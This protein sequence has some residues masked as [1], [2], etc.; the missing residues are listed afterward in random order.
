MAQITSEEEVLE[1]QQTAYELIQQ[2]ELEE[3][4]HVSAALLEYDPNNAIALNFMGIIFLEEQRP[5][6]AYQY[7]RRAL[8]E[9]SDNAQ[10]W[11]NFGMSAHELHRNSEAINSYLKSAELNNGYIKAYVNA[12][13]VF[14]EESR[15]DEAEKCCD[16]A[17]E[18]DPDN[19]LA[20]K[21]MAHVYLAKHRWEKGWEYWE[22]SLGCKYRKEWVYGKEERWDGS[23]DKAV[24]VYGEQGLGDEIAYS[25]CIPDLINDSKKVIIDCDPRLEK[26]F[27]RSFPNADVYGTRR[28]QHPDWLRYAR[29]DARVAMASLPSFYRNSDEAFPGTPYLKPD[30]NLVKMFRTYFDTFKKPVY[31]ICTHGGSK[32]TNEK[33]RTIRPE[34]FSSLFAKDAV[35]VS[36][37]YKSLHNNKKLLY[38]P[39]VTG[40]KDYDVT[41]ALIAACDAVIGVNTTAMHCA[42][43]MGIPTH[44]LVSTF[45]QWRYEGE[46]VWSKTAKLYHQKEGEEWRDVIKRVK[47]E[48]K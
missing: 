3:A 9:N 21:N 26:L 27:T 17:L 20:L 41:A 44:I 15:W 39:W 35:F 47:L 7:L 45:H 46:Y 43:A 16:T 12:A 18:I 30:P 6:L 37:D 29:I 28:E 13:A 24:V 4:A 40:A 5:E 36:L 10:I 34:D 8:Q 14:I 1:A 48:K 31:G 32:L 19:D 38:F 33:Q 23:R 25:S 42:N 11:S 22:K 2:R